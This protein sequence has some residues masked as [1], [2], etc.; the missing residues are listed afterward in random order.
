[1]RTASRGVLTQTVTITDDVRPLSC[2]ITI[3][4]CIAG[5]CTACQSAR[6]GTVTKTCM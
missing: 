5:R 6:H 1:M 2:A 3:G 4:M